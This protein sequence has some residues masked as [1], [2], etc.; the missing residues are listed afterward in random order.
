MN[1]FVLSR[2]FRKGGDGAG[3][4][5]DDVGAGGD[6]VGAGGDDVGAGGDDVGAGG[7]GDGAGADKLFKLAASAE[8]LFVT[9]RDSPGM[10]H[11]C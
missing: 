3:V 8:Y 10:S 7:D 6:D 1:F 5:G 4:G 9:T 11:I 2:N